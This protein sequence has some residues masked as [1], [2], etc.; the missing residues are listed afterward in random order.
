MEVAV[1]LG[2]TMTSVNIQIPPNLSGFLQSQV[3]SG[4]YKSVS[5]YVAHLI[6]SDMHEQAT[7]AQ[8][9]DNPRLAEK[10]EAGLEAGPSR[11]VDGSL[12]DELRRRINERLPGNE[13]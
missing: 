8:L 6:E 9:N 13:P 7:L 1:S 2:A 4:G 3:S 12:F 10:L 5:D 11:R